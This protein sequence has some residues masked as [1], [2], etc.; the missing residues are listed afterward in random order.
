MAQEKKA[1]YPMLPV[2]HW[3]KLREKFKQSIPGVVTDSYLAAAL[4]TQPKSARVNVL[5]YL[6]AIGLIDDE[7]KTQELAKAW[8]DDEQYSDV[9]K[10]IRKTLYPED[11]I[12][13]V[14]DPS[15]EGQA[16]KRWF[17][18]NTGAG[19]SAVSRMTAF[20]VVLSDA[21][22]SKKPDKKPSKPQTQPKRKG[23]ANKATE[24]HQARKSDEKS[25]EKAIS[26]Q[27]GVPGININLEIHIS[28]DATP[29][30][31][32]KIFESMAKHIYGK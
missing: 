18:N 13:A 25:F 7:G 2:A 17:A 32:D 12:S 22:I 5:P 1:S 27:S 3:W 24:K 16:V 21:D 23:E 31:I 9:C 29:D 26:G 6:K 28:S 8:R 15:S 14:S 10:T 30:Q 4:D 11:L 19:T 20:Y